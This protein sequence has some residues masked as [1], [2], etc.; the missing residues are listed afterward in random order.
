M[1]S[2]HDILEKFGVVQC[3]NGTDV[4]VKG[5]YF[6][7][8]EEIYNASDEY[9]SQPCDCYIELNVS[10]NLIEG[11]HLG[12]MEAKNPELFWQQHKNGGTAESFQ[13]IASYI[14]EVQNRLAS[15]AALSELEE[16]P[17]LTDCIGIYFRN[18]PEVLKCDGYYEFV[19]NGRHRIL[20]ARALGYDIPVKVIGERRRKNP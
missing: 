1:L 2:G 11:I 8:F 18:M 3:K 14:P 4:F 16:D 7:R 12:K 19:G 6:A 20:A 17:R 13:E 15:G 5:D 9:P 10:P